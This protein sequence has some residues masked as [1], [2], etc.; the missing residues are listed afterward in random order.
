MTCGLDPTVNVTATDVMKRA[1]DQFVCGVNGA[2]TDALYATF[3]LG[4]ILFLGIGIIYVFVRW[5]R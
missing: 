1:L 4:L 5:K 2:G 3:A